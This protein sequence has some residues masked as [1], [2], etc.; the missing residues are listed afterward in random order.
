MLT[1]FTKRSMLDI[2]QG[3]EYGPGPYV[4]PLIKL[5]S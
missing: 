1:I 4:E 3:S 2:L 5:N